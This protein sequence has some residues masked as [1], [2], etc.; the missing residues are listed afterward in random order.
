MS[1]NSTA[2]IL[3]AWDAIKDDSDLRDALVRHIATKHTRLFL[4]FYE[5]AT[6]VANVTLRCG[7]VNDFQENGKKIPVI[8]WFREQTGLGL[9]DSK[10][11]TEDTFTFTCTREKAAEM[12]ASF[13]R[14]YN[15]RTN[16]HRDLEPPFAV[17][18]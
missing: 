1:N 16:D 4:S 13:K 11:W 14:D 15:L 3:K 10:G 5:E 9:A 12:I 2:A 6:K 7:G 18:A 17:Q 8:R